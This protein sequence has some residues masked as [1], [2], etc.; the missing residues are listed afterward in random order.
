MV[1]SRRQ[2][3]LG[4]L[5]G[6]TCLA[7]CSGTPTR[8]ADDATDRPHTGSDTDPE[9]QQSRNLDEEPVIRELGDDGARALNRDLIHDPARLDDLEFS[10]GV[11]GS[12]VESTWAFLEDTDYETET[13]YVTHVSIES[14]YRYHIHSVSWDASGPRVDFEYCRELRPPDVA[15][16]ATTR[17]SLGLFFRLP[18]ALD[19]E[20]TGG[21]SSGRSPC[22]R[23]DTDWAVIDANTS[24]EGQ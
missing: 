1:P 13:I 5:A 16:R 7:G 11:P 14:C 9:V 21:G 3:L 19:T 17:E 12:D 20:L 23:T 8:E 10:P 24:T 15:C 4:T 22:R 6:V 18:V 2:F